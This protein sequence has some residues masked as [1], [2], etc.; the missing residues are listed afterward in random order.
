[1]GIHD[2]HRERMKRRFA[3]HGLDNFNDLNVLE[4]LLFYA[5]PRRDTN[6]VAHALLD[7]FGSVKVGVAVWV[8]VKVKVSVGV[9]V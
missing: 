1:M 5:L 8:L 2:G 4:L 7:R 6:A 9:D 3:E